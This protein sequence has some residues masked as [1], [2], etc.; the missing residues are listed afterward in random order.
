MIKQKKQAGVGLLEVLIALLLLAVG[1][2]GYV[3]LQV[4]AFDASAE[5]MQK[6]Q[7]MIIMRG[8]ADSMRINKTQIA[9]YS[10]F[11]RSYTG[12]SSS[13]TAPASCFNS[14]CTPNQMAQF[15]AYQAARTADQLG[16]KLAMDNCPGITSTMTLRRQCLYAFW[17]KTVPTITTSG[18]TTSAN[19]S[20]CM[21]ADGIYVNGSSCLMLEVY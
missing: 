8:L 18:S 12:F 13:T 2:L 10:A 15:D 9:N 14:A 17:G 3:A 5:A 21:G 11:V 16:I 4:R 1:V 19:V 20:T 7:A 6:S